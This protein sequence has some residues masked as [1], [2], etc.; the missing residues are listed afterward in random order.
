MDELEA[1]L[2]DAGV[3]EPDE[4]LAWAHQRAEALL[5]GLGDDAELVA[6]LEGAEPVRSIPSE[7]PE[8]GPDPTAHEA[9][10]AA[11]EGAE[12]V[13]EPPAEPAPLPPIPSHAATDP[14]E[15]IEELDD[16]ELLDEEDLELVE[17]E[18]EGAGEAPPVREGAN[19]EAA[20]PAEPPPSFGPPNLGAD[21]PEWKAALASAQVG[22]EHAA[23][24]VREDSRVERL[25]EAP[26]GHR[27][28]PEEDEISQ[29][30]IDLSDL[31]GDP[32][33]G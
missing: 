21:V 25:P 16:I 10:A 28:E 30:R 24:K 17:D 9:E 3:D 15:E 27:L 6:L 4:L 22:D 18:D 13:P 8:P 26:V 19:G 7:M 14:S 11:A 5:A 20:H 2:R 29:H 31:D 1:L 23:E 12:P 33:A 32:A